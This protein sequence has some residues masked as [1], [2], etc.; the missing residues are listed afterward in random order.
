MS[1]SAAR[2]PKLA[3]LISG[4]GRN[5][6]AILGAV[7]DGR[8]PARA[9]VVISNRRDAGG[10]EIARQRG[11]PTEVVAHADYATRDEFDQ[12]LAAT[13][14]RY[15]PD[16]I[17]LAGFMRVLGAAFVAEFRGRMLNIHPSLLPRH[18]GLRTHERAIAAGDAEHGAT[19]HFVTLALDGG[20]P[21][22]Q[23]ALPLHDA[24][25][26]L[27]VAAEHLAECVLEVIELKIFPQALAWQ[28]RGEL[29]LSDDDQVLFRSVPLSAPR[30]LA[31]LEEAFR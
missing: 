4:R 22:I 24:Q 13:L 15:R 31:D 11:V 30:T 6:Q 27:L 23:G 14:R 7:A 18:A 17:A 5:L 12:A 25:G 26:R 29:S 20:P 2:L 9:V 28:A 10:L 3:V 16:I 1:V 21:V 19:V 8:I